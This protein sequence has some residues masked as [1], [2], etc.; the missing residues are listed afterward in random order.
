MEMQ[1]SVSA[2][3]SSVLKSQKVI[4]LPR[5]SL[6]WLGHIMFLTAAIVANNQYIILAFDESI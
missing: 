2:T 5:L 4:H 6:L 1:A 3:R